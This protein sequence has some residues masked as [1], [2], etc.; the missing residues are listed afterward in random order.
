MT[1]ANS[2]EGRYPFLDVDLVDF[3]RQIPPDLKIK[4]FTEKYLIKRMACDLVPRDIVEREKFGFRAPGTPFLLRQRIEWIEDLLA[5]ERIARQGYFNPATIE[6]LRRRYRRDGCYFN[7]H[8][9]I[10]LLMVVITFGLLCDRFGLPP[11]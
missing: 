11:L 9:E 4:G 6:A 5:P 3:A 2:V 1:L 7:P 8:L 10:D